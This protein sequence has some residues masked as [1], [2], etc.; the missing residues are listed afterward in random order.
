MEQGNITVSFLSEE[1]DFSRSLS[2]T[3]NSSSPSVAAGAVPTVDTPASGGLRFVNWQEEKRFL[4]S[5]WQKEKEFLMG[6]IIH[7]KRCLEVE[8]TNELKEHENVSRFVN[9]QEAELRRV[10]EEND[11]IKQDAEEMHKIVHVLERENVRLQS[12]INGNIGGGS[13]GNGIEEEKYQQDVNEFFNVTTSQPLSTSSSATVSSVTSSA[14]NRS[15]PSKVDPKASWLAHCS[16][17]LLGGH[18]SAQLLVQ[19]EDEKVEDK[20]K[21][22]QMF[23][24]EALPLETPHCLTSPSSNSV[25]PAT[26]SSSHLPARKARDHHH[27]QQQQPLPPPPQQ[28]QQQTALVKYSRSPPQGAV[29]AQL[30]GASPPDEKSKNNPLRL[31]LKACSPTK[32]SETNVDHTYSFGPRTVPGMAHWMRT[33]GDLYKPPPAHS[34][35]PAGNTP[36]YMSHTVKSKLVSRYEQPISG[37]MSVGRS[38][39]FR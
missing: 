36:H 19:H 37:Q 32:C 20:I 5:Q 38:A 25:S 12:L 21:E 3:T 35:A 24:P 1:A 39:G 2:P 34:H 9:M 22:L 8:R 7:L 15:T 17:Q 23:R 14:R 4:M 31:A 28:Q 27:H 26:S 6:E 13:N 29:V 10:K 18:E 33:P 11:R 30:L 16:T